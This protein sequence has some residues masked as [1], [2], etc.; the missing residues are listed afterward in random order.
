MI[1]ATRGSRILDYRIYLG[2]NNTT[3]FNVGRNTSHTLDITISGDN[4][5][6]TRVHG[7]TL[8]VTDDFESNRIGDYCVLPFNAS[9]YVNIER[10]ER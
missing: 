3:D 4:E 9:L 2:E 6:D 7:Y 5:V 8:S 10:A 1:R